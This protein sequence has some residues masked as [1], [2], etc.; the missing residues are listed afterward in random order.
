MKI[1]F[2]GKTAKRPYKALRFVLEFCFSSILCLV[3]SILLVFILVFRVFGG[4]YFNWGGFLV[5]FDTKG[6][7]SWIKLV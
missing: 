6:V 2:S 3:F 7:Q 4:F 1:P 5:V